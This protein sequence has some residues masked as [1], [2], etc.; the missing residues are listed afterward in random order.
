MLKNPISTTGRA[1]DLYVK[2]FSNITVKISIA[3]PNALLIPNL[4]LILI[5]RTV[6]YSILK[7]VVMTFTDLEI[8]CS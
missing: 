5:N 6:M 3:T 7:F 4:L 8:T 1:Q 2:L